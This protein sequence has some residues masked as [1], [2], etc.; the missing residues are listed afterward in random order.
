M[1]V[2]RK[3]ATPTNQVGGGPSFASAAAV[4][5]SDTVPLATAAQALWIGGAG[6]VAVV[7]ISG[8]TVTLAAVAAGTLLP[9]ACTQVKAT[10]TT[11]TNILALW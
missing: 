7:T 4:T 8:Q 9:L 11:A 10:G 3:M 6:S 2:D 1:V 5:P